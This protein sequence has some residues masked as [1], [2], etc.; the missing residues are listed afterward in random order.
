MTPGHRHLDTTEDHHGLLQPCP[1]TEV[2][3]SA[4]L[5]CVQPGDV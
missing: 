3:A 5:S 2:T 4:L 1:S